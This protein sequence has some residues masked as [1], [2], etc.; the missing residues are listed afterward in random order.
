VTYLVRIPHKIHH[1]RFGSDL[2]VEGSLQNVQPSYDGRLG[3]GYQS[4]YLRP[5]IHSTIYYH[6]TVDYRAFHWHLDFADRADAI[7]FVLRWL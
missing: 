1:A 6:Y 7:G 4:W 2:I 5:H 3:R